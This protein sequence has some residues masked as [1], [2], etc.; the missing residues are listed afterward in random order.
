MDNRVAKQKGSALLTAL[1]IM[2][3][4]AITATAMSTRLRLDIYRTQ[5]TIKSDKLYLASQA[6]TFWS[7]DKLSQKEFEHPLPKITHYPERYQTLYPSVEATGELIDL[8]SKFNINNIEDRFYANVFKKL[9][10]NLV[11]KMSS[12]ERI[13]LVYATRS[14]IGKYRPGRGKD[15]LFNFYL[16]QKPSYVPSHQPLKSIS[17]FRLIRDVNAILYETLEPYLIALP[18]RTP[19][20]I[21]TASTPILSVMGKGLSE[22]DI[23]ELLST[24]KDD[25]TFD[26][27]KIRDAVQKLDIPMEQ[28]TTESQFYLSKAVVKSGDL[29]LTNYTLLNRAKDLKGNVHV[30]IEIESLNTL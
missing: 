28:I 18:G 27:Q 15:K 4:V 7:M 9:I 29:T 1:F 19:I 21:R 10:E 6:V 30:T 3:L 14:W 2:T 24:V 8:Q 25:G 12:K 16:S 20:N 5:L 17:E 11:P 26:K 22:S 13:Q 23:D